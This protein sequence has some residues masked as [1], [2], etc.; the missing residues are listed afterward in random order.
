M[1]EGSDGS[2]VP[3]PAGGTG[4]PPGSEGA[5]PDPEASPGLTSHLRYFTHRF[6][7]LA[8]LGGVAAITGATLSLGGLFGL[9][10]YLA[11]RFVRKHLD[12]PFDLL[13]AG[14]F[15]AAEQEV[16]AALAKEPPGPVA[17]ELLTVAAISRACRGDRAGARAYMD[18]RTAPVSDLQGL[19]P[20]LHRPIGAAAFEAV[21]E[22]E[23]ALDLL[24]DVD[25]SESE[26]GLVLLKAS[27][28]IAAGRFRGAGRAL[29]LLVKRFSTPSVLRLAH[30][31]YLLLAQATWDPELAPLLR[32]YEPRSAHE[33]ELA[34]AG[35]LQLAEFTG[36][37]G[38]AQALD[39]KLRALR[40]E[41]SALKP[42]EAALAW[43]QALYRLFVESDAMEPEVLAKGL[44]EADALERALPEGSLVPLEDR[45]FRSWLGMQAALA[46][47]EPREAVLPDLA[48]ELLDH[49]GGVLGAC[50]ILILG[51]VVDDLH[52]ATEER[53]RMASR[54]RE[55]PA[56]EA[57]TALLATWSGRALDDEARIALGRAQRAERA[58]PPALRPLLS[59]A[60]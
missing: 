55:A 17:D 24:G 28:L 6:P 32:D 42:G 51:G 23:L 29:E 2:G 50:R 3:P 9:G 4:R 16:E 57:V 41:L 38:E 56:L 43:H 13:L 5:K 53:M 26:S 31:L 1:A 52:A 58:F 35:K 22:P 21:G 48:N 44:A 46:R 39:G 10:T 27:T 12:R 54:G 37:R 15:E 40:A 18:R 8:L 30:G 59:A 7:G 47:G 14:E 49:R 25:P 45:W 11:Y 19:H 60:G 34:L 20:R 33:T 36:N